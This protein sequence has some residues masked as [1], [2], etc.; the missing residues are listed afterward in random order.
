MMAGRKMVDSGVEWIGD[1]PIG[2]QISSLKNLVSLSRIRTGGEDFYVGMENIEAAT[3]RHL[4]G[5]DARTSENGIDNSFSTGD[6]LFGKLRPYLRKVWLA[7]RQGSCSTEFLVV[8]PK[9]IESNRFL[10]YVMLSAEFCD[11]VNDSCKG[12]KMPRAD[13]GNIG[14]APVPLPP[15]AEQQAI[16][17]YLD[18]YVDLI[19]RERDL[20]AKKIELLKDKRQAAIFECVTGKRQI[21]ETQYLAGVDDWSNI[22]SVGHLAAVPTAEDRLVDSGVEWIGKVPEGWRVV[23]AKQLVTKMNRPVRKHYGVVTC[24][25]DGQVTLRSKRRNDGF[26]IA[27][28]EHGY[29]GILPGDLV[30][31]AMD[32]FA[33]AVGVSDSEGKCSPVYSVCAVSPAA[34]SSFLSYYFR[35]LALGGYIDSVAKGI[36]ERSTDFRFSEVQRTPVGLPPLA[37]QQAIAEYLDRYIKM[38]DREMTLLQAKS[39]IL[40]SKRQALIFE[41]VTGKINLSKQAPFA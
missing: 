29:Q 20:I 16:A 5:D 13:W 40:S 4:L 30:I 11:L 27:L 31:H 33:G 12:V 28:K 1:V 38:I 35:V 17:D 18:H 39:D 8:S 2:W 3:G 32:A 37:E 24:F 36:R 6:I 19:D 23:Q 7:D 14:S 22:I 34:N 41:A 10:F 15:L 9:T 26:T 25:R 21:V